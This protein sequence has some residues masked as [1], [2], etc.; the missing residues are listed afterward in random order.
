MAKAAADQ[1]HSEPYAYRQRVY[2][3]LAQM[4]AI[5]KREEPDGCSQE[6]GA[7]ELGSKARMGTRTGLQR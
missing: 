2:Q 4:A 5:H 3:P 6:V 7:E 1:L